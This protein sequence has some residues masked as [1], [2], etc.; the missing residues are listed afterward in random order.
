M[1]KKYLA[2][3]VIILDDFVTDEIKKAALA[4]EEVIKVESGENYAGR[5]AYL[6]KELSAAVIDRYK[7]YDLPHDKLNHSRIRVATHNDDSTFNSLVHTDHICKKVLVLY[8][9]NTLYK[10]TDEAG[11]LFWQSNVTKKK[12][13]T[14]GNPRDVLLHSLVIER[15]TKDLNKWTKWLSCP[16]IEGSALVF[17]SLYFHSP[18]SPEFEKNSPGKRITLDLFLD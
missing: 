10:N 16:F 14:L 1:D 13:M 17:D 11:T 6:P 5:S 4:L 2:D 3:D 8:I 12:K 15:D 9:Q 7:L 18:P